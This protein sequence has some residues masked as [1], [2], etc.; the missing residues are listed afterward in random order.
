M[1]FKSIKQKLDVFFLRKFFLYSFLAPL[2]DPV[3]L[4][5]ISS[6]AEVWRFWPSA[7]TNT[8]AKH[9]GFVFKILQRL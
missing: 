5:E 9:S 4:I 7:I 6:G 2:E 3:L 1:L 8:G